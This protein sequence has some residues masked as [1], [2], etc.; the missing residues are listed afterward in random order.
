MDC[1][2][3]NFESKSYWHLQQSARNCHPMACF[4]HKCKRLLL[5]LEVVQVLVGLGLGPELAVVWAVASPHRVHI[6][7]NIHFACCTCCLAHSMNIQKTLDH[8]T[9]PIVSCKDLELVLGHRQ[10]LAA[11]VL[12]LG[13]ADKLPHRHNSRILRRTSHFLECHSTTLS[14]T[15]Q[16][17]SSGTKM[18]KDTQQ[19]PSSQ[20]TKSS[21]R[22]THRYCLL[23]NTTAKCNAHTSRR[24]GSYN[25]SCAPQSP[26]EACWPAYHPSLTL[27]FECP[28]QME[29]DTIGQGTYRQSTGSRRLL[30]CL[31]YTNL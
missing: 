22:R 4:L 3:Q 29:E 21:Q 12:D 8:R 2:L 27:L 28:C 23:T 30:Y 26:L 20:N 17:G 7:C 16:G 9:A 19:P 18:W 14:M 6:G 13:Q 5:I 24:Q 15:H 10:A 31:K 1:C 25:A 11:L